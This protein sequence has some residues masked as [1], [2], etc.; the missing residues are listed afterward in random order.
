[1]KTI[2]IK[3]VS[4]SYGSTKALDKVTI[5]IE[6]DRI[7]GLLGRNGAGKTT[8]LNLMTNRIF[9]TEG[10]ITIDGET[11]FENDKAL[12]NVCYM[13]EQNLYPEGERIKNIFKWT[14]EFYPLFDTEYAKSL[15]GK[16]GLNINKK[17][18]ELST[19]YTSIFKPRMLVLSYL[20]SRYWAWM[21][22][23]GICSIRSLLQ[24]ITKVPEP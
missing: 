11:V 5:T 14:K 1:M 10:N 13:T 15:S 20:M 7:Y 12:S 17:V 19:G 22:T 23:I 8:L 6:P 2:E 3:G 18:K 4:K 16:F 9:P 24:I 21:R